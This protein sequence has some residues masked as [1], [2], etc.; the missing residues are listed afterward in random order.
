MFLPRSF[1]SKA[2][3]NFME[4][5]NNFNGFVSDWAIR[6]KQGS[7]NSEASRE[8]RREKEKG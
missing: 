1:N 8:W 3:K 2:Y 5:S 7:Q 4:R 6:H